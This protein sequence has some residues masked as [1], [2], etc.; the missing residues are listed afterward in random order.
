MLD[1]ARKPTPERFAFFEEAGERKDIGP[2]IIEKDF[3]VCWLLRLIFADTEI[4]VDY[5]PCCG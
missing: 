5:H 2:H 1:F 4:V 3:W